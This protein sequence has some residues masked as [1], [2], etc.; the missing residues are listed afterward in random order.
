MAKTTPFNGEMLRA[1]RLSRERTQFELAEIVGVS[2]SAVSRFE[3]GLLTPNPGDATNFA[4]ALDCP[5]SFSRAP[6]T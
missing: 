3:S 4:E 2:V 1:A 6:P 5:A